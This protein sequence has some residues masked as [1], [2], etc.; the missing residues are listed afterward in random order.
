MTKVVIG[1]HAVLANGYVMASLGTSQIALV[2]QA[3]NVPISVCCETLNFS[4]K[5]HIDSF[6]FNE[7]GEYYIPLFILFFALLTD[8]LLPLK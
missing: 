7:E 2:S 1:A 5:A 8:C 4:E 3:F 6:V